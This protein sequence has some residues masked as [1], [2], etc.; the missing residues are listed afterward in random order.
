MEPE[1]FT[2]FSLCVCVRVWWVVVSAF[3][4]IVIETNLCK[5]CILSIKFRARSKGHE[6]L[7]L[8]LVLPCVG[9]A[10]QAPV[11]KLEACVDLVGKWPPIH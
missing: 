1:P 7:R 2:M 4:C 3:S 5:D 11:P 6:K 8:I 9:H 10:N